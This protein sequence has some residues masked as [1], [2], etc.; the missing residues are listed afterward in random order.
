MA[1][2]TDYN[3]LIL[4]KGE[5]TE[6]LKHPN[7]QAVLTSAEI[8]DFLAQ[9][10]LKDLRQ[11]L[12]TGVSPKFSEEKIL[13]RWKLDAYATMAQERKARPDITAA[14]LLRLKKVINDL[15]LAFTFIATTDNKAVLKFELPEEIRQAL[16]AAADAQNAQAQSGGAATG[17]SPELS[18]RYGLGQRRAAPAPS[19]EPAAAP[20]QLNLS[21]TGTWERQDGRYEL[22]LASEQGKE[23]VV[24]ATADED[25]LVIN[26]TLPNTQVKR[27]VFAR[28]E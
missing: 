21:A 10:D 12:E 3:N 18:A 15:S 24:R 6:I 1:T 2:D 13:G 14:E 20:A 9:Q 17:M 27:L 26:T 19:S 5:F 4:S 8:M 23:E 16:Q 11:Y 25:R 7:T 22:K 28:A